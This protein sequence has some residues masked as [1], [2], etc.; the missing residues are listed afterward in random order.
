[1]TKSFGLKINKILLTVLLGMLLWLAVDTEALIP[2]YMEWQWLHTDKL[3]GYL[4]QLSLSS[5]RKSILGIMVPGIGYLEQMV[6]GG[7]EITD[8]SYEKYLD[9]ENPL[10]EQ[11][12]EDLQ[13][14]PAE[15]V[16]EEPETHLEISSDAQAVNAPVAVLNRELLLDF[17]NLI[18]EKYTITSIT[19]LKPEQFNIEEALNMDMSMRQDN[20]NPQILIFHTHSQEAFADSIAG[21]SSTT[22]V[23]IG[24]Y[25]AELLREKYGYNVIHDTGVYDLVDGKLDRSAA[26]TYAEKGLEKILEEY[27]SIEVII[28]LHR[29]GVDEKTRL[30]TEINGKPTAKIMLFNGISYSK[31]NGNLDYLPNPYIGENLAMSLQLKLLGDLYY[32]EFLRK[33]YINAY[34]YC[35]HYR[36]KSMLIEAGAQNNTIEEEKNAMELLAEILHRMFQGERAYK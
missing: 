36:G 33:N 34:R 4:H 27:P 9:A 28:D 29:D 1:M 7:Y 12:E 21:D 24:E 5:N 25:L 19:Q 35:L 14:S 22:I 3:A 15:E 31:V 23:G 13:T 32:P 2:G 26:Y 20:Q 18:K 6:V 30:V 8:P 17:D 16:S 10:N 11:P